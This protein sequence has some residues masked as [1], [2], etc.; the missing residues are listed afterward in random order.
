MEQIKVMVAEDIALLREDFME[1]INA[2]PDM[3]VV[4]SAATGLSL[5]HI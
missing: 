1:T 2:Q 3:T 4:G 5:I